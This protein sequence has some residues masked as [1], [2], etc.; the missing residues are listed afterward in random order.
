MSRLRIT[1]LALSL[2]LLA[3]RASADEGAWGAARTNSAA[4]AQLGRPVVGASSQSAAPALLERPHALEV[5]AASRAA[6]V[7]LGSPDLPNA[8]GKP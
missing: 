5:G 4:A 3:A 6:Q 1:A 7:R 2:G 8:G